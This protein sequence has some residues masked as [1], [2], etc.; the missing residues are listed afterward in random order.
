MLTLESLSNLML[1]VKRLLFF[2]AI[3]QICTVYFIS[4]YH[5]IYN[6]ILF[7]GTPVDH[8]CFSTCIFHLVT[9]VI[10]LQ[11]VVFT[12]ACPSTYSTCHSIL[13]VFDFTTMFDFSFQLLVLSS[14]WTIPFVLSIISTE[15]FFL[16]FTFFYS[17]WNL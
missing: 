12:Y 8:W 10:N 13:A 9:L 3:W 2:S 4:H 6:P 7:D 14:H 1:L 11:V 5:Y 16:A 15:L 17:F